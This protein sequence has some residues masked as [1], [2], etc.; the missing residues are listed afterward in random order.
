MGVVSWG[1]NKTGQL[2]VGQTDHALEMSETPLVI[3]ALGG[4][5]LRALDCGSEHSL[6]LT[7]SGSVYAWGNNTKGQCGVG[8]SESLSLVTTPSLVPHL[9]P[10]INAIAAGSHVS[11]AFVKGKASVKRPV[12]ASEKGKGSKKKKTT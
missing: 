2:G 11:F 9:G 1:A 7:T 6:A 8:A 12:S 4:L 3:T 10:H 5:P